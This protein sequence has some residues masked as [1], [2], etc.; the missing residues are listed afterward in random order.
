MHPRVRYAGSGA[1]GPSTSPSLA[2]PC[3]PARDPR[4]KH[5]SSPII[6]TAPTMSDLPHPPD[7]PLAKPRS[8]VVCRSRK[9]RCDKRLPCSNC[10][11]ANIAC[12]PAT[13]DDR[14]PRWAR[15]LDRLVAAPPAQAAQATDP[16]AA[17][18]MERLRGLERLVKELG[19]QLQAQQGGAQSTPS[20]STPNAAPSPEG[21]RGT[22]ANSPSSSSAATVQKNFGRLVVRDG[23]PS[24]YVG[25]GFWSRV[26]DEVSPLLHPPCVNP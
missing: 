6:T 15:R 20:G 5:A 19:G 25:S 2:P 23:A 21:S 7:A 11:R 26:S 16:A 1:I 17:Q 13:S 9:V 18:V 12:V 24:Q 22:N 8:C 10:R 3:P 14:P 4:E